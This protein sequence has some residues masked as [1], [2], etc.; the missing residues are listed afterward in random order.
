MTRLTKILGCTCIVASMLVSGV[1]AAMGDIQVKT[2]YVSKPTTLDGKISLEE[3]GNCT[4]LVLDGSGTNTEGTWANTTWG[5]EKFTIYTA[6][7][8]DN[9]YIGFTVEG[10]TTNNQT[11]RGEGGFG[12]SD[13]IQLGFN[14]GGI[15][16]GQHPIIFSMHIND[17]DCYVEADAYRSEE[18]GKQQVKDYKNV[19]AY[20]SKYS[21]D[22]INY[23]FE[24]A[25][26][27]DELCVKGAGRSGEGAI[28][29][30]M[31]GERAKIKAGY[32][33]PF[34]FI[35]TDVNAEGKPI[36]IRTDATTGAKWVAE[37]MGS[38]ALTL[39]A[40]PATAT[41]PKTADISVI[42]AGL[43]AAASTGA[44]ITLK[45]KH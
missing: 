42:L 12:K 17:G 30:D 19:K 21:A 33:L 20:C 29:F 16:E 36:Y 7:D 44:F 2:G 28:V 41:A 15:V 13:T 34:I 35:Y 18:D 23:S 43:A 4:P 26:P 1:S 8:K 10:D 24:T 25:I 38:I 37:E 14:P 5:T 9:L 11:V 40:A 22:G 31:T 45:K 39:Q 6:W 32:Q 27:W 3:Y